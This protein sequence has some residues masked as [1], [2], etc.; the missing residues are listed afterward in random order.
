MKVKTCGGDSVRERLDYRLSASVDSRSRPRR[1]I[2]G[3]WRSRGQ[4]QRHVRERLTIGFLRLW[5]ESGVGAR[6]GGA[7][8]IRKYCRTQ[9]VTAT[10]L[11]PRSELNWYPYTARKGKFVLRLYRFL[12][13]R[14]WAAPG[15]RR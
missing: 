1:Q 7:H 12:L 6:L 14:D 9:A 3:A 10:R 11:T 13:A 15:R 5:K 8:G 4:R 2:A